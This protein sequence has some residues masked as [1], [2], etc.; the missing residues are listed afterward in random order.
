MGRRRIHVKNPIWFKNVTAPLASAHSKNPQLSLTF[1]Q[2]IFEIFECLLNWGNTNFNPKD[3][4]LKSSKQK[5]PIG[6]KLLI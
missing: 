5:A 3:K 4:S 1:L 2:S 6:A